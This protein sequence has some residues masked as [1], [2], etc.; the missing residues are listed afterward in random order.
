MSRITCETA[1]QCR[2]IARQFETVVEPAVL[3]LVIGTVAL[4]VFS[5]IYSQVT[6]DEC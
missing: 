2:E 4:V 3:M 6:I 5:I 1:A